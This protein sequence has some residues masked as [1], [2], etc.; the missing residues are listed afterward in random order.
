MAKLNNTIL[1]LVVLVL[2]INRCRDTGS[3]MPG[4]YT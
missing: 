2:T 4:K 1:Y 3:E